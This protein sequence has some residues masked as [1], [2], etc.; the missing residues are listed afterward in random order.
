LL[1]TG[2]QRSVGVVPVDRLRKL[3]A[4]RRDQSTQD[5]AP[6]VV[7]EAANHAPR[8][9]PASQR[10]GLDFDIRLGQNA[11]SAGFSGR[12]SCVPL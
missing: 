2:R 8:L 10:P 12:A 11:P 7:F 4:A 6:M 3:V 5:G 9:R 1:V